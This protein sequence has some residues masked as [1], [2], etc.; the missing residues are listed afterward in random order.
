MQETIL[1]FT[2]LVLA[3]V[4]ILVCHILNRTSKRS[5]EVLHMMVDLSRQWS[6]M[7]RNSK[8]CEDGLSL[9]SRGIEST[10]AESSG[11]AQ[12]SKTVDGEQP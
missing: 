10:N 9:T 5:V 11:T 3:L 7:S 1:S 2:I 12:L 8:G 4:Q 6:A